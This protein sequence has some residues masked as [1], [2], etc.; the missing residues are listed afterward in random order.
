M[1]GAIAAIGKAF[2]F[3]TG[4]PSYAMMPII[5]ALLALALGA[6]LKKAVRS[7]IIVG[8]GFIGIGMATTV[9]F[10][11]VTPVAKDIVTN[12]GFSKEIV[13]VGWPVSAQPRP[14]APPRSRRADRRRR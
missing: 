2:G 3:I 5:I 12:L 14:R 4:F 9:L 7:G 13:D 10:N 6:E 8:I 1:Q 11:E